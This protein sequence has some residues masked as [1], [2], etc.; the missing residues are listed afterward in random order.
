MS[1]EN[2]G[3]PLNNVKQVAEEDRERLIA[4]LEERGFKVLADGRILGDY[5]PLLTAEVVLGYDREDL[6]EWFVDLYVP[7]DGSCGAVEDDPDEGEHEF[8]LKRH[9][10]GHQYVGHEELVA[11]FASAYGAGLRDGAE[12]GIEWLF[13]PMEFKKSNR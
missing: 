9:R 4:E 11:M 10:V 8:D 5:S 13:P 12:P 6:S 7:C 2:S 1:T 3:T